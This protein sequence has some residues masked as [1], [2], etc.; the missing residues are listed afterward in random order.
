M[1][2][3]LAVALTLQ[4]QS[5][6]LIP[7]ER[8]AM[9]GEA[10][11]NSPAHWA[12][13]R[14]YLFNSNGNPIR[15]SG[16]NFNTLGAARAVL[17][18]DYTR[19]LRW[20][21]STW[22]DDDG[23]LY[24]WYHHEVGVCV[25]GE[26]SVPQIGALV[27]YD[28]GATFFD[29]GIV[30]EAGGEPNC[31]A[32]NGYFAGGHGDFTVV[33]DRERSYF[34][35]LFSNYAGETAEQGVAIARL[36]FEDRADPVGKVWKYFDASWDE[37]GLGGRVTPVFP[38]QGSWVDPFTDAL[39]GPSVHWNTHLRQWVML[40]NKSCCTP[41]WPQAG[42][43][44]S[45]NGDISNPRSWTAPRKIVEGGNWYPQVLGLGEGETDKEAGQ[46]PRLFVG[47]VSDYEL[48]FSAEPA[49]PPSGTGAARSGWQTAAPRPA[50][51]T[52]TGGTRRGRNRH[53]GPGHDVPPA[54]RPSAAPGP[55]RAFR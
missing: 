13:G 37:P 28:N 39:W 1:V 50:P 55:Y 2:Y 33:L 46:R 47:G 12:S 21:E 11:S 45:F 53:R 25:A 42:V 4:A 8:L 18:Y 23:T 32:A 36:A 15:T 34:Y 27:S 41:G 35:F 6:Q 16:F 22:Q 51:Q 43:Y 14:F 31:Q 29:L 3:V 40:M 38:V 54:T 10:D 9:P 5:V 24:A 44:V 7:A 19:P 20:I 52:V 48:E 26:M 17:F 49:P 30:L